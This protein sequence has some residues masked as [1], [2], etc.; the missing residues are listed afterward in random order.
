M[1]LHFIACTWCRRYAEQVAFLQC[2][3]SCLGRTG[4]VAAQRLTQEGRE[5]I[6]NG[7]QLAE[8]RGVNE[9]RTRLCRP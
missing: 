3:T 8:A 5:R 7:F 6:A 9:Q 4:V 2:A 1:Q